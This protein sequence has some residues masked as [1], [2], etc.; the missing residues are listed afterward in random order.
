MIVKTN[1]S[2]FVTKIIRA[3]VFLLVFS[4]WL[5]ELRV[6]FKGFFYPPP[7]LELG[8][9]V[10]LP[11]VYEIIIITISLFL[12]FGILNREIHLK[13]D[14]F[15]KFVWWMTC[16]ALF[17]VPL[18]RFFELQEGDAAFGH[19][20]V[21]LESLAL[22]LVVSHI[23]WRKK[24]L[25]LII[26]LFIGGTV[27]N[28]LIAIL[29]TYTPGLLFLPANLIP[30]AEYFQVAGLFSQPSRQSLFLSMGFILGASLLVNRESSVLSPIQVIGLMFLISVLSIGMA[31]AQIR[32]S[33]VSIPLA[34][35][36]SYWSNRS[37]LRSR[38]TSIV[39][40][41]SILIIVVL[42]W[43]F[44]NVL[45]VALNRIT[46]F[47]FREQFMET[48]G[49]VWLFSAQ[50]ILKYPFG[51]GYDAIGYIARPVVGFEMTHAHNLF[52]H[53]AVMFGLPGLILLLYFI[54]RLYRDTNNLLISAKVEKNRIILVII[55]PI[56]LFL[57]SG[58][59]ESFFI[60]NSGIWFWLFAGLVVSSIRRS[61]ECL[62]F[63]KKGA[64]L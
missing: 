32:T 42:I 54:I 52:L 22:F 47:Q 63:D 59:T 21:T 51:T 1:S 43:E 23:N 56:T 25:W 46:G 5:P 40:I 53:W 31:L 62:R 17:V 19:L 49:L 39:F 28:A 11:W 9:R 6:S 33:Y 16:I 13:N 15:F 20:R 30:Q 8:Y 36:L 12:I 50:I 35:L 57:L 55:S 38:M 64:I 45:P 3:L 4:F 24:D 58:M 29:A 7:S 27:F 34:L 44:T 41:F 26:I 48:R 10:G 60:T 37:E 18:S 14:W 2:G 61:S